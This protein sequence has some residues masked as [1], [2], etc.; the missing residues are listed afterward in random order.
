M[1]LLPAPAWMVTTPPRT[2]EMVAVA[3]AGGD[4]DG[5]E[6]V[7]GA[8]PSATSALMALLPSPGGDGHDI[9]VWRKC[10][11]AA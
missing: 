3:R 8:L 10:V 11:V 2:A 6:V 7:A 1:A 5:A 9:A 4:A